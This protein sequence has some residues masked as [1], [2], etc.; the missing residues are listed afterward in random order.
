MT[1]PTTRA[2]R[3]RVARIERLTPT[4]GR[5]TFTG[6]DMQHFGG[7]GFDQRIKLVFPLANGEFTDVGLFDEPVAPMTVWYSRWRALPEAIKNPIRTYTVRAL[8]P[9]VAELDVDFVLHGSESPASAW[10][11][12]V[13]VGDEIVIIGP[14]RR[15]GVQGRG[16]EWRPGRART[17][18][19]AGDETAAPAICAIL[20]QLDVDV[21]GLA[22][23]EVPTASDAHE[24][25]SR[26]RVQIR[27]MPRD[28]AAHGSALTPAVE[29]WGRERRRPA[30]SAAPLPEPGSDEVL[31]EAPADVVADEYAWLAG[32]AGVVTSLRRHLVRDIGIDRTAVAFMGYW[33][34]GRA[35][36]S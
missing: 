6:D 21:E 26:S 14:D 9:H 29:Q 25:T 15:S 2:F 22:L 4:F 16:V 18:L 30:A 11:S 36:G 3:A 7:D 13:V 1:Y 24:L 23:I 17:V 12:R 31:W 5:I 32:E 27:W 35:E 28:G 33:R 10:A 20:E 19:I 34:A 8:R